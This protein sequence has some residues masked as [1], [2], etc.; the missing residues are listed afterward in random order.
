LLYLVMFVAP[1]TLPLPLPPAPLSV[2]L[3]FSRRI[4]GR[5]QPAARAKKTFPPFPSYQPH[6]YD[7]Q[8]MATTLAAIGKKHVAQG[9][10]T[11]LPPVPPSSPSPPEIADP[12]S[13]LSHSVGRYTEM[14]MSSGKGSYVQTECGRNLLDFTCG[15]TSI[16][17]AVSSPNDRADHSLLAVGVT[18]LGHVHPGV[19]KKAQEQVGTLVHGQVRLSPLLFP[20]CTRLTS[21]SCSAISPTTSPTSS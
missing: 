3:L 14:V 16:F 1:P 11:A 6:P 18:N 4:F 17:P 12:P 5:Q 8:S 9:F 15:S 21:T 2:S 7:K 20:L 10:V 13:L 19:T